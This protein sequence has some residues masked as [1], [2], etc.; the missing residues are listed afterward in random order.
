MGRGNV[1]VTGKSECLYYIS[2]DD[3]QVYYRDHDPCDCKLAGE[4]CVEDLSSGEWEYDDIGSEMEL[5]AI[6]DDVTHDFCEK[7]PS[8]INVY[9]E[10]RFIRNG[11]G[12]SDCNRVIVENGLFNLCLADNEWSV[13][14]ALIQKEAPYG[15]SYDGLQSRH[16]DKLKNGLLECLLDHLPRVYVRNGPWMSYPITNNKDGKPMAELRPML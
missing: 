11:I 5:D 10:E 1:C 14:I 6:I 16:F 8:F 15:Y 7:F 12:G 13:A 4:L 2:N 9:G 3:F